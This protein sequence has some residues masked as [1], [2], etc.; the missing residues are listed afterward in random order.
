MWENPWVIL[1]PSG[2]GHVALEFWVVMEDHDH[3]GLW[4]FLVTMRNG[5]KSLQMSEG[6]CPRKGSS[7]LEAESSLVLVAH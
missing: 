3:G 6:L 1:L 2:K 4:D 5:V 7:D